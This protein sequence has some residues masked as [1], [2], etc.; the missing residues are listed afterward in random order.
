MYK[1]RAG[2]DNINTLMQDLLNPAV[3]DQVVFDTPDCQYRDG[4]KVIHLVNDAESNVF[5]GDIGY[6]TDPSPRKIYR[7]E[8][9]W[10]D[11]PI[12][13]QWNRLPAQWMVQDSLSLCDEY[14]QIARKRISVV[15][16]PITN[17]SHRMLQRN[18]IYTAIT[19][20]KSKLILLGEYSALISLLK[21]QVQR[22]RPIWLN[23]SQGPGRRRSNHRLFFIPCNGF[24]YSRICTKQR[25]KL[26]K[27]KQRR[28]SLLSID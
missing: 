3:K 14:S 21:I 28:L 13:W 10:I 11:Y 8:A 25:K 15:I 20:S 26:L 22:A 2:I 23:V 27:R 5:N 4:D 18:L 17:Q 9:R 16:L 1:G 24:C 6:I 19:R 12:W 7:I